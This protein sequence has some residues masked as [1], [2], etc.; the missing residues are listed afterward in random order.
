MAILMFLLFF[1][2]EAASDF[3][4]VTV[5]PGDDAI[6]PCLAADSSIR[7]V[8]WTRPDLEPKLVLLN[9]DGHLDPTYQ[10]PDFKDRVDLVTR[11]LKDGDVSLILKNVSRCDNGTYK[12][13]V[14]TGGSRHNKRAINSEPIR[15]IHLQVTE[16]AGSNSK[17]SKDDNSTNDVPEDE[18]SSPVG[19]HHGL[20]AGVLL[21]VAVVAVGG[22]LIYKRH[23]DKRSGLTAADADK[24]SAVHFI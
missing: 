14:I 2:S 5:H 21:L 8:E 6:L 20:A 4:V 24:A 3:I 10:H 7:A 18:N 9:I 12:C 22:V 17:N 16:P 15:S 11:D 13:R 19:R 23:K 1:L